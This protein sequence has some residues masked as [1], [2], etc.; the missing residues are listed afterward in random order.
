MALGIF[1]SLISA[2]SDDDAVDSS[3]AQAAMRALVSSVDTSMSGYQTD[4]D[5]AGTVKLACAR[6]GSADVQGHVHVTVDPVTVD[7]ELAIEYDACETRDGAVLSGSVDFVQTVVAGQVPTR[8]ETRYTGSVV[9]SGK[10]QAD[11]AVDVRALVD[12]AGKT[13]KVTGSFCGNDAADLNVEVMPHWI[14]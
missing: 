7:V 9:F 3:T 4:S 10:V 5:S 13:V 2:C 8:V 1:A 14:D 6:G 12:E 11:C